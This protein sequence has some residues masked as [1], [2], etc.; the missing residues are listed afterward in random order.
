MPKSEYELKNKMDERVALYFLQDIDLIGRTT[1][2]KLKNYFE[3]YINIYN[4]GESELAKILKQNML[5]AFL[6]NRA[7]KDPVEMY[8]RL[9]KKGV[10]HILYED[11]EYPKRLK[12]IEDAPLA[13]FVKNELPQDN[14]PSVA[15]IGSRG[16]S[17]YGKAAAM[18]YAK[19]LAKNDIQIISGLAM[20]IDGIAQ[21]C[22]YKEG[23]M[24]FGVLGCGVDICYPKS[25][26]R[27]YDNLSNN[28]GGLISE[29]TLGTAGKKWHFPMRNRIISALSDAVIVIEAR[30]KSG[31]L[32]TVDAALEQ[33]KDVFALPGRIYDDL[34]YGCNCLIRQ[35]AEILISPE[36]FLE[37]FISNIRYRTQFS[38]YINQLYM[39][40]NY[41][42]Q[43]NIRNKYKL[44]SPDEQIIYDCM[45]Y[46]PMTPDQ[47]SKEVNKKTAMSLATLLQGLTNMT[48]AGSICNIGCGY[49]V[50]NH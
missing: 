14:I 1:L 45:E 44:Q 43:N 3:S 37:D 26:E 15:I 18:E 49:Y 5:N 21:D 31:T 13:I 50:K 38:D 41:V 33:G 29:Y 12:E 9:I 10:R 6:N 4:A 8:N 2:C 48:I 16:C 34:S 27:I 39:K 36:T 24:T 20:G 19:V 22:A 35:G 23:G 47:I 30:E 32:I 17:A 40:D 42:N 25:N 7:S 11:K 46:T 28:K